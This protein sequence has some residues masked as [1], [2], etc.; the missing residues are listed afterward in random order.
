MGASRVPLGAE[1]DVSVLS[2]EKV[3]QRTQL[4]GPG[5]LRWPRPRAASAWLR[6]SAAPIPAMLAGAGV[7]KQK[8]R[9]R[10]PCPAPA[11]P[12]ERQVI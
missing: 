8:P 10:L 12:V 11:E 9:R 1:S 5:R 6:C 3:D 4:T 7:L 2:G